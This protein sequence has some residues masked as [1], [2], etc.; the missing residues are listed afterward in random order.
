MHVRMAENQNKQLHASGPTMKNI[1]MPVRWLSLLCLLFP[2][3]QA[4]AKSVEQ[5]C[6]DTVMQYAHIADL[7][8]L[9]DFAELFTD[10]AIFEGGTLELP[11]TSSS[12]QR[13][14]VR[15]RW[16]NNQLR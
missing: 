6:R 3:A 14:T 16:T 4:Q 11:T 7:G 8:D 15:P 12:P 10:D 5:L 9:A 13:L 1:A 2:L